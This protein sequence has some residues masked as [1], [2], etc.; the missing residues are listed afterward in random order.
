MEF[1]LKYIVPN[2]KP[3]VPMKACKIP[4]GSILPIGRLLVIN[5]TPRNPNIIPS[6]TV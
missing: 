1:F 5:K 6:K 4:M 3:I 2:E